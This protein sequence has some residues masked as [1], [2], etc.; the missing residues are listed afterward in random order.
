MTISAC[1]LAELQGDGYVFV[2]KEEDIQAVVSEHLA[3]IEDVTGMV[4]NST[5]GQYVEL[6]VTNSGR[7]FENDTSYTRLI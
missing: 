4:V 1:T 6:W 5:C 7:P 3:G 2:E